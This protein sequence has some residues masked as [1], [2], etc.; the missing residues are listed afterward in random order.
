MILFLTPVDRQNMVLFK[1][2]EYIPPVFN[3]TVTKTTLNKTVALGEEVQFRINVTNNGNQELENVFINDT[4]GEGLVYKYYINGTRNWNYDSKNKV[5]TLVDNLTVGESATII[6]VFETHKIG[7]LTNNATSGYND[8][9]L[10]NSTNTTQVEKPGI[11]VEKVCLNETSFKGE[12]VAFNVTVKNTAKVDLGDVRVYEQFTDD[13]I[14]SSHSDNEKWVK[15]GNV[16]KYYQALKPQ[17]SV[18]FTIWFI[19][20]NTG[21]L[22]NNITVTTNETDNKTSNDTVHVYSPN[23][24]IKK[25]AFTNKEINLGDVV[26][27][28]IYVKN[29]GDC[30]LHNV[31]ITEKAPDGLEYSKM[32]GTWRKD[33]DSYTYTRILKPGVEQAL[34]LSYKVTKYG[35]LT[36]VVV[37][38]SSET[39]NVTN[40]T[41]VHVIT[42][43]M[44]VEK[45]TLNKTVIVGEK[46]GFVIVVKNTGE[47]NLTGVYVIDSDYAEGLEYDNFVDETG[48][49]SYEGNGK[50]IY[51]DALGIGESAKLTIVF[52]A[53]TEGFKVNNVTAGNNITNDTVNSTNTT[54]VTVEPTQNET[55]V[56]DNETEVP[57]N[58][59]DVPENIT[60]DHKAKID[61]KATGNPLVVLIVVLVG[62]VLGSRRRKQ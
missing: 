55:D 60:V 26:R 22:L 3:E 49:W 57:E 59:T 16:F 32:Q 25:V 18:T 31:T 5:W 62:L 6:L 53:L 7:V 19:T 58:E 47:C 15:E 37:G 44:A 13:L 50:W 14:Y 56:P 4:C 61:A 24:T 23:M 29:T 17:E 34:I 2:S 9:S 27:F 36:N 48:K 40:D 38:N 54:N 42:P 41:T 46:V 10:A 35:N 33:G 43:N 51:N 39:E 52:K 12:F 28:I 30:D 45:L 8:I 20:N 1:S 21:D 11:F